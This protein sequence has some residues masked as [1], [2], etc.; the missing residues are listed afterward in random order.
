MNQVTIQVHLH[1]NDVKIPKVDPSSLLLMLRRRVQKVEKAVPSSG[2]LSPLYNLVKVLYT[3]LGIEPLC[4]L[5]PHG[6]NGTGISNA[7]SLWPL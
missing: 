5:V 1:S 6:S 7:A 4:T 3:S 2:C